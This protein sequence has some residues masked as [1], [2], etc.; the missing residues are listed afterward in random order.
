MT[1]LLGVLAVIL[2]AIVW[3]AAG[4]GIWKIYVWI[5]PRWR[6]AVMVVVLIAVCSAMGPWLFVI[7][8][9]A[10]FLGRWVGRAVYQRTGERWKQALATTMV[11]WLPF[12][13]L[14]PGTVFFYHAVYKYGGV[15]IYERVRAEGYLLPS[16]VS[17]ENRWKELRLD[18]YRRYRYIEVHIP[19]PDASRGHIAARMLPIFLPGYYQFFTM[20]ITPQQCLAEQQ[21]PDRRSHYVTD[22]FKLR[23]PPESA[24]RDICVIAQRSNQPISRYRYEDTFREMLPDYP[25]WLSVRANSFIVESTK[26]NQV[27]AQ[28]SMVSFYSW[29]YPQL[30]H[31]YNLVWRY[32]RFGSDRE[33]LEIADVIQPSNVSDGE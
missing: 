3:G 11:L 8:V 30:D 21:L 27:I 28:Y 14:V 20:Q 18:A 13:D 33:S 2:G 22:E 16:G 23:H 29:L 26:I 1:D 12:W 10:W 31:D 6:T 5:S 7:G 4:L 25:S 24:L 17:G 15:R 9:L 19:Q 32:P